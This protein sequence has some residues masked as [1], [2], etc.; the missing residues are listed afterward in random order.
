MKDP[1]KEG[2]KGRKNEWKGTKTT[3]ESLKEL[4]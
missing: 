4:K 3:K 1:K 2:T